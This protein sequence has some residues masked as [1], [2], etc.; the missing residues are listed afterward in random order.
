MVRKLNPSRAK[1]KTNVLIVLH[2]CVVILLFARCCLSSQNIK[3]FSDADMKGFSINFNDYD[4]NLT[5][6]EFNDIATSACVNGIWFLYEQP[7]FGP[8]GNGFVE[9][10]WGDDHCFNIDPIVDNKVSSV[11]YAGNFHDWRQDMIT[12]YTHHWF[13]GDELYDE[14]DQRV[15]PAGE[16]IAKSA[17]IA[18]LSNWTIYEEKE[19][20]GQAWCL[21]PQDATGAAPGFFTELAK[22]GVTVVR[23]FRKG[24]DSDRIPKALQVTK[25]EQ[26]KNDHEQNC[27]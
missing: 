13:Q 6:V 7:K 1:N 23:S 20:T 18:G 8:D 22:E 16:I 12:L 25:S 24:C 4:E 15:L 17:V 19:Y 5:R 21:Q 2:S 14:T 26:G 9:F 10:A 3:L 11:K 27:C